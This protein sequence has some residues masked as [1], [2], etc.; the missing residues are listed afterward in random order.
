MS[1]KNNKPYN[2][3]DDINMILSFNLLKAMIDRIKDSLFSLSELVQQVSKIAIVITE[4]QKEFSA[5]FIE[6]RKSIEDSEK[7]LSINIKDQASRIVNEIKAN[8]N[9]HITINNK[10]EDLDSRF[11][12]YLDDKIYILM[13]EIEGNSS[14]HKSILIRVDEIDKNTSELIKDKNTNIIDEIKRTSD[15]LE[16][17]TSTMESVLRKLSIFN[18]KMFKIF[19]VVTIIVTIIGVISGIISILPLLHV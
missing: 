15:K 14:D 7:R 5:I 4:N 6:I 1:N 18:N 11:E 9:H 12:K 19:A 10:L 13:S 2:Q 8:S 17:I 16:K 3:D